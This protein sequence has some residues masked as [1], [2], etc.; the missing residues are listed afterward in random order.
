MADATLVVRQSEHPIVSMLATES[1]LFVQYQLGGPSEIRVFDHAG[2]PVASPKQKP[3]S[4]VDGMSPLPGDRILFTTVSYTEPLQTDLF[5]SQ[6]ETTRPI[7]VFSEVSKSLRNVEVRREWATSK[8]GTRIPVNILYSAKV[9]K[10]QPAPCV[11]H[12]YGGYQESMTPD[13]DP[14][15][16]LLLD[17]GCHYAV[18]CIRGGYEFGQVWYEQGRLQQKQNVFDDFAAACQHLISA[19]YTTSEKLG[20]IGYSNGGL[21]MGAMLTQ[22]P[23]LFRTAVSLFGVYDML[24]WES[25]TNGRFN[26]TEFGTVK[27]PLLYRA[28]R[29]YS[30]YHN[31][32]SDVTYPSVLFITSANDPLVDPLQSRKMTARLQ[33]VTRS[34]GPVLLVTG[35][36]TGHFPV[37]EL[38]TAAYSFLLDQL[39]VR[40]GAGG[41]R[42]RIVCR[43]EICRSNTMLQQYYAAAG[44]S[45]PAMASISV[46]TI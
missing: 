5:D 8:D 2:H 13:F 32:R 4:T 26:V 45:S 40:I 36:K 17:S 27:D 11:I 37:H 25:S 7:P 29:D 38:E 14:S 24:R 22:H 19:G 46:S 12:G 34:S 10:G 1:R 28:L 9:P 15:I 30:P 20:M 44:M 43:Q 16:Q 18:V 41:L 33:A 31:V 3:M 6:T 35:G 42:R 39:G 21:L 23:K